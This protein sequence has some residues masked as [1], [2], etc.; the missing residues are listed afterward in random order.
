MAEADVLA[1]VKNAEG[2][3]QHPR[4]FGAKRKFV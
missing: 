2:L 1:N 4:Y 3:A